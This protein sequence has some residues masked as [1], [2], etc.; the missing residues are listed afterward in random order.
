MHHLVLAEIYQKSYD[1]LDVNELSDVFSTDGHGSHRK[2]NENAGDASSYDIDYKLMLFSVLPQKKL[3]RKVILRNYAQKY[4]SLS[5]TSDE[6]EKLENDKILYNKKMDLVDWYCE[7]LSNIVIDGCYQ[8]ELAKLMINSKKIVESKPFGPMI[9]E[10]S[11]FKKHMDY[12]ICEFLY[13]FIFT[14]VINNLIFNFFLFIF[15]SPGTQHYSWVRKTSRA[16]H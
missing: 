5:Q 9:F 6:E 7:N 10:L 12:F 13:F 11:P 14:L 16:S 1:E 15:I 3:L 8:T 2:R 4:L